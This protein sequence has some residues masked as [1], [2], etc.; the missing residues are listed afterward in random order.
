V[1]PLLLLAVPHLLLILVAMLTASR[2]QTLTLNLVL[3]LVRGLLLLLVL[4]DLRDASVPGGII[5]PHEK[6]L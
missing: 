2:L 1:L 5:S 4:Q 3:P 6:R